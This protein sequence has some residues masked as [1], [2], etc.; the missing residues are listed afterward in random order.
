MRDTET[1]TADSARLRE[2]GEWWLRLQDSPGERQ[3]AEWIAWSQGDPS[4]LEAFERVESVAHEMMGFSRAQR[5][6]LL[7][8][9]APELVPAPRRSRL[10][11]GR[12]S[13]LPWLAGLAAALAVA[14][15]GLFY[16]QSPSSGTSTYSTERARHQDVTLVDG[17][18]V[19]VGAS[20]ELAVSMSRQRRLVRLRDGEAYFEVRK[21][22]GRPFVVEAGEISITAIGTAF[23]VRRIGERVVVSVTEGRV[24]V[25]QPTKQ[26]LTLEAGERLAYGSETQV[27]RLSRVAP[28]RVAGW[29][30]RRLEFVNEPLDVVI[31]DIN[32][33]SG[34][35]LKVS[36]EVGAFTFTGTV[37][38][39]NLQSWLGALPSVLPVRVDRDDGGVTISPQ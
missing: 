5:K 18:R 19:T 4:N 26:S 23:D 16:L 30:E 13:R 38:P 3:T 1:G 29:R 37:S 27:V 24:R 32:R 15:A 9:F 39:E 12:V 21:D 31:A 25:D 28:E 14:A 33:Y 10:V 8:E 35:H 2:A 6:E 34:L 36:P 17:S 22:P 11:P 7:A 20:S